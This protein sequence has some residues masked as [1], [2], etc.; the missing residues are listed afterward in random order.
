MKLRPYLLALALL[1]TA[2]PALA[3]DPRPGE[4]PKADNQGASGACT[5]VTVADHARLA[6]HP[7]WFRNTSGQSAEVA[8][9][10][11]VDSSQNG[12]TAFGAVLSNTRL[13]TRT[14]TCTAYFNSN[15]NGVQAITRS[16]MVG[17]RLNKR[18]AWYAYEDT[19]ERVIVGGQ[20]GLQ[21]TLPPG[22]A[23]QW[24]WTQ[25]VAN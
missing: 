19:G 15:G 12:T 7:F 8:C 10:P 24:V 16:V 13:D 1:A 18:I 25:G 11:R 22:M 9:S 20:L 5:P 17:P 21:C 14:V 4:L 6:V 23:I 3:S 2:L